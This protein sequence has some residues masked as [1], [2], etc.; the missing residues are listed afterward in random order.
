MDNPNTQQADMLMELINSYAV[1]HGE[2]DN[3]ST[4]ELSAIDLEMDV[5]DIAH[6]KQASKDYLCSLSQNIEASLDRILAAVTA[7]NQISCQ[8]LNFE[9]PQ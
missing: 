5:S 4:T 1:W 2:T 6:E 3:A 9:G 8:P 7:C